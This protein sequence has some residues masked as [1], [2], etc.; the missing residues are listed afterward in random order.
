MIRWDDEQTRSAF[1]DPERTRHSTH[2]TAS[3]QVYDAVAFGFFAEERVG[4]LEEDAGTVA[5]VLVAAARAAVLEVPEELQ[6]RFNDA[7]AFVAVD[8]RDEADAAGVALERGVV[9]AIGHGRERDR[10]RFRHVHFLA[11][12]FQLRSSKDSKEPLTRRSKTRGDLSPQSRGEVGHRSFS[13]AAT[14]PC[15]K[16]FSTATT[17]PLLHEEPNRPTSPRFPGRGRR[18][19]SSGG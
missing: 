13:S 1:A 5:G 16:C 17:N 6:T 19:S 4:H 8:V 12:H 2:Q 14:N 18:E 7:V 11:R 15:I 9:E 3:E 10:L